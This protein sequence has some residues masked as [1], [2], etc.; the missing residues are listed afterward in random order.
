MKLKLKAVVASIFFIPAVV[1]ADHWPQ[2]FME[3]IDVKEAAFCAVLKSYSKQIKDA[4]ASKNQIRVKRVHNKQ[5]T[6]IEA[7]MP[8]RVFQDWI[9]MVQSIKVDDLMN[10]TLEATLPCHKTIVGQKIPQTN[11]MAYEQLADV[12]KGEYVLVSGTLAFDR[13]NE[14]PQVFF[15]NFSSI[16]GLN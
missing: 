9:I 16:V 12:G 1:N 3:S 5:L 13:N 14:T 2:R 6:D 8:T 7:L 4:Q 11:T 15:A 10:A